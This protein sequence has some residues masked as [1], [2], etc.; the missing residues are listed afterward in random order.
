MKS[1]LSTCLDCRQF[2]TLALLAY[3]SCLHAFGEIG[4]LADEVGDVDFAI[5]ESLHYA[6]KRADHPRLKEEFAWREQYGFPVAG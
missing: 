2:D 6:S 3:P 4:A 1:T 5:C